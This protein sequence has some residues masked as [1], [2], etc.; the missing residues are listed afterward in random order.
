M[1]S[2]W[3]WAVTLYRWDTW[4]FN[5]LKGNVSTIYNVGPWSLHIARLN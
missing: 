1:R 3:E 2:K 5:R 4:A